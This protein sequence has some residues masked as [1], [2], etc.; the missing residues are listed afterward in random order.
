MKLTEIINKA[1][2]ERRIRK[3]VFGC[4][5]S[6]H[7]YLSIMI[8]FKEIYPDETFRLISPKAT[9]SNRDQMMQSNKTDP[10][11]TMQ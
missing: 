6:G 10:I 5:P 2:E 8:K 1:I 4:E 9:T 11:D 7:Y 3:L